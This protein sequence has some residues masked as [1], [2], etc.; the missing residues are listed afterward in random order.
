MAFNP[1]IIIHEVLTGGTFNGAASNGTLDT[2]VPATS[3][4]Y[5]N[6][7]AQF[8]GGGTS[9]G[10]IEAFDQVGMSIGQVM[11]KGA[12]TTGF[13]LKIESLSYPAASPV[14]FSFTL[15]DESSLRDVQGLSLADTT[16]FV[17]CPIRPIFVPPDHALTFTTTGALSAAGRVTFVVGNGWGYRTFQQG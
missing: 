7:R 15:F 5:Y 8:Y 14:S 1:E 2:V 10:K 13:V 17:Y 16:S 3:A 11:F 12:G 4:P 6:G 9:G